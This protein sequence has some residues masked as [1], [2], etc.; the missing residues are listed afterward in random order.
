MCI[1]QIV[2]QQIIY[3]LN[4]GNAFFGWIITFWHSTW[5]WHLITRADPHPQDCMSELKLVSNVSLLFYFS[6]LQIPQYQTLSL[7]VSSVFFFKSLL[8]PKG[9]LM[10][11]LSIF[12]FALWCNRNTV[13]II[14][15]KRKKKTKQTNKKQPTKHLTV[16]KYRF[17][18]NLCLTNNLSLCVLSLLWWYEGN[19]T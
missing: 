17:P 11:I 6:A 12:I 4:T 3:T 13:F 15:K 19:Q 18:M 7:W 5:P 14:L 1:S 16:A 9:W 8:N 2:S 10:I